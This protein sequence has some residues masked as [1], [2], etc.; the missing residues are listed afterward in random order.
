VCVR[1]SNSTAAA[2]PRGTVAERNYSSGELESLFALRNLSPP[3]RS[4][5][6]FST[7]AHLIEAVL[8]EGEGLAYGAQRTGE[9]LDERDE[10]WSAIVQAR[11]VCPVFFP[12]ASFISR[13]IS[14]YFRVRCGTMPS[15]RSMS[16]S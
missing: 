15:I 13:S 2:S 6:G 7:I 9:V 3:S 11:A 4:I 14:A 1:A 5:S 16:I 8:C 12:A 10:L